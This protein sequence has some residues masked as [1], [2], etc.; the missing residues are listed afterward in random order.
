MVVTAA[1]LAVGL[2]GVRRYRQFEFVP[3]AGVAESAGPGA[4]WLI[5]G[6]DSRDGFAAGDGADGSVVGTAADVEGSRTDTI[7]VARVDPATG[8]VNLLSVPRDLWVPIAGRGDWGRINGAFNGAGGR[9]R[10][11]ATVE[12][13]LQIDITHYAE[14]NLAG[15]QSM[16]DAVGGVTM[17]FD[18]P[19]RDAGSGLDIVDAGCHQLSGA[20]A[21]SY[22]R[23]R[24]LEVMVDGAWTGEGSGDIGRTERQRAF[25]SHMAAIVADRLGSGNVVAVDRLVGAAASNV[26]VADSAGPGDLVTLARAFVAAGDN[27]VSHSLPVTDR[28][29]SGGAQVLDL[30]TEA[31]QPVLDV[32]RSPGEAPPAVADVGADGVVP[33]AASA[34][35]QAPTAADLRS[36]SLPGIGPEAC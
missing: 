1:V 36:E 29:T 32:F 25:L 3:V 21:L 23:S 11:V 26:V 14:V 34:P 15:F 10:L 7:M 17:W 2:W 16:V 6:T 20:Q 9:E 27:V 12:S 30:Q 4:N 33:G 31:A 22:V 19:M 35:V 13:A 8:T 18:S 5:V 24:K 28:V